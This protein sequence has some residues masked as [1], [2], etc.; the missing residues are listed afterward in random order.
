MPMLPIVTSYP[1]EPV[2][3]PAPTT[4]LSLDESILP[5]T[6]SAALGT[7]LLKAFNPEE[8]TDAPEKVSL[9]VSSPVSKVN[10]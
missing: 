9:P 8:P 5:Y 3:E 2:V 10:L 7:W 1:Q 6:A 4:P